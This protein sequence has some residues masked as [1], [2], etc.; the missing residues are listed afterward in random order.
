M[1]LR[2]LRELLWC[3]PSPDD[4][5]GAFHHGGQDAPVSHIEEWR[6]V[7]K[8][9]LIFPQYL[10]HERQHTIGGEQLTWVRW[11]RPTNQ[12]IE[13]WYSGGTDEVTPPFLSGQKG[14][15]SARIFF[16]VEQLVNAGTAHVSVN[17][18]DALSKLRQGDG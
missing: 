10:E 14:D 8:N 2:L 11:H 15:Q 6:R 13:V 9:K 5:N 12:A 18:Q 17:Q 3:D 1:H 16:N 7:D 4:Q